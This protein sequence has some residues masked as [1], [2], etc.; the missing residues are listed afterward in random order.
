ME[1][2]QVSEERTIGGVMKILQVIA[3]FQRSAGTSVF[4]AEV[5]RQLAQLGHEVAIAVPDTKAEGMYPTPESVELVSIADAMTRTWDVVHIH[6]IWTPI[7]TKVQRWATSN[8][9]K[10]VWSPHGM[11][12]T[13]ALMMKWPKKLA[14]LLVYQWKALRAADVIHVCSDSEAKNVARLRLGVPMVKV[15]LGAHFCN[16]VEVEGEGRQSKDKYTLLYIGR[17][18]K[19]KGLTN[20]VKAWKLLGG[21]CPDI[22]AKWRVVI[23]G[24]DEEGHAAELR[25]LA[26]RYG[27]EDS[28]EVRGPVYGE[29]KDELYVAADLFILPSLSENFGSVILESLIQGV[30]AIATNGTPWQD[31]PRVGC[32][33]C[34]DTNP[35]ALAAALTDAICLPPEA[36]KAKGEI[37]RKW[38]MENF[39]WPRVG[40]QVEEMY[41]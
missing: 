15:P 2:N 31:L 41:Q 19:G 27:L 22:R 33:W 10:L 4:C 11:L 18:N 25:R 3:I 38:V 17:V 40:K 29:E 14:G 32:G 13:R 1:E 8:K 12:Q 21:A 34:V 20:L 28:I 16:Q 23:A 9:I 35:S 24:F 37:G 26:K 30:P 5:A 7:L 6:G 36:R 39:S